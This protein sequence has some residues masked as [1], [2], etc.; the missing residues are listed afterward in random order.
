M[1]SCR[2]V[3]LCSMGTERVNAELASLVPSAALT[4]SAPMLLL[5]QADGKKI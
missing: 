2:L 3:S 4:H 1:I 5:N